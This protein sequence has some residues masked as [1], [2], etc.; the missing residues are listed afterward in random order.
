[1]AEN[2][3]RK[4]VNEY[5][6]VSQGLENSHVQIRRFLMLSVWAGVPSV[7][8]TFGKCLKTIPG[9]DPILAGG[10]LVGGTVRKPSVFAQTTK[11]QIILPIYDISLSLFFHPFT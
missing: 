11:L 5:K 7:R 6:C 9:V 8:P 1:M 4:Y 2:V 3:M 10:I